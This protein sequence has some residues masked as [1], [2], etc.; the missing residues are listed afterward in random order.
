[1]NAADPPRA[2]QAPPKDV[3]SGNPPADARPAK[4]VPAVEAKPLSDNVNRGLKWLVEHQLKDGAWGQGEESQAMGGG[5][6]LKDVPSV[7]D[8]CMAALALLRSGSSPAQGPY[9]KNV[10][11][12][13]KFV[14]GEIEESD[15]DTLDVTR[16]HSTRVQMKLGT[17]IDTFAASLLLAEMKGKMPDEAGEKRLGAALDKLLAKIQKNQRPDGTWA[18][19]GWATTMQQNF[20]VKG[21]NRAAQKGIAVDEKVRELAE[22]QA[23]SKY[24]TSAGAAGGPAMG[25]AGAMGG[26]AMSGPVVARSVSGR[27]SPYSGLA[28]PSKPIAAAAPAAAPPAAAKSFS[29]EDSAGVELYSAGATLSNVTQSNATNGT[30]MAELKQQAQSAPRAADRAAAAQK[31]ARFDAVQKDQ[32]EIEKAVVAKL[33]DKQFLAGFGSNGGEEFL[34]YLNIGE[35]LVVKGGGPWKSWDK[36]ITENL[37]R[38]QNADG[39]WSGHHCITGRTFCTSAAM[40]VL[41]VDRAPSSISEKMKRR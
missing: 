9:A 12:A 41:M 6:A 17:Y 37:N 35:S 29:K 4:L 11:D 7:A 22:T 36:S 19:N 5:A 38:I 39:S 27:A 31:L 28:A 8:T 2:K 15:K 1:M 10:L 33:D 32:A 26:L 30:Q 20:A 34:S 14:C 16:N 18:G 3:K 25:S 23:R 24:S 13:V 40:L 21:I